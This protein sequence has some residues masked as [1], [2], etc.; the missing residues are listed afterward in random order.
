MVRNNNKSDEN[1]IAFVLYL[2]VI[3][4]VFIGVVGGIIVSLAIRCR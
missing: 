4:S 1:I 3:I 2:L